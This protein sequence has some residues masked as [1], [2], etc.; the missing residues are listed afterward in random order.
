MAVFLVGSATGHFGEICIIC[1]VKRNAVHVSVNEKG[2]GI[3]NGDYPRLRETVAEGVGLG[4]Q[5]TNPQRNWYVRSKLGWRSRKK[6][7]KKEMI[8]LKEAVKFLSKLSF[9]GF[10]DI[11][12]WN[13]NERKT[14]SY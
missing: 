5:S 3:Q 13:K 1:L 4:V 9:G 10:T 2:Y 11:L 6:G 7:E 8:S 14:N 12:I